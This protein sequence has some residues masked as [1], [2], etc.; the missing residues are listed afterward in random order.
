MSEHWRNGK[1]LG[2]VY[3][4]RSLMMPTTIRRPFGAGNIMHR[5]F[6]IGCAENLHSSE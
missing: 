1:L 5:E 4:T 3:A 2:A 6:A